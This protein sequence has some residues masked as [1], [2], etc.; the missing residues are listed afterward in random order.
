MNSKQVRNSKIFM[1]ISVA[2]FVLCFTFSTYAVIQKVLF[3]DLEV[4]TI[5]KGLDY[6]IN[7]TNG[8]SIS[9]GTL[10]PSSDYSGGLSASVQFYKRDDTYDIYGHIYLDVTTVGTGIGVDPGFKYAVVDSG[11]NI[12]EEDTLVAKNGYSIPLAA[13]IPLTVS[14]ETYSVYIWID[15]NTISNY[16]LTGETLSATIRCEATMEPI[17]YTRQGFATDVFT[18]KFSPNG[19]VINNS[20]EYAVDT[21][22]SLIKDTRD[23]I[24][25]YGSSPNNYIYFNCDTYPSTNCETWR[26][27]GVVDGKVKLMRNT[28]IGT[29]SWDTSANTTAGN[30]GYGITQWGESTYTTDGS[31][32]KGADL[33]RLLN[34][35]YETNQDVNASDETIT[36]N[37]SLYYNSGSGTCYGGRTYAIKACDFTSTGVQGIKNAATR[38]KI[39]VTTYY[40]GGHNANAIYPNVI[41]DKERGTTVGAN[42][43][44]K[45]V[46]TTT[47]TGRIA[48]PYPSDY[49]YAADLSLCNKTLNLYN[50]SNCIANN[51]MRT[52]TAGASSH[53]LTTRSS[54]SY[55]N[56]AIYSSG[57]M[58]YAYA[59]CNAFRVFPTLYLSSNEIIAGGT[60][61]ISDPYTLAA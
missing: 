27:I 33:M 48:L 46:R 37:N 35:G 31:V 5:T 50:D 18:K 22:N 32:Y 54:H 40:L 49:A 52:I 60:G 1:Y 57:I 11:N 43:N 39:A 16:E 8:N 59:P 55:H 4:S 17:D 42:A 13:N 51:W 61:T 53:L 20:I 26:I 34:P 21:D 41:L 36:V 56:W 44:D 3:D 24:R 28:N 7:Y 19:T 29:F 15:E 58:N 47:W 6:Y 30:T 2:V 10:T 14:Q 23:N 9:G 12:V 25:Y 45:V 38:N